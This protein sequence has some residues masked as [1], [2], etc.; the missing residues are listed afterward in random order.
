MQGVFYVR[1]HP[2]HFD[3]VNA[4]FALLCIK[5]LENLLAGCVHVQHGIK[6]SDKNRH[7]SCIL[8]REYTD[9]SIRNTISEVLQSDLL[10]KKFLNF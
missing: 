7:A 4:Y 9:A 8:I 6:Q 1:S 2:D 10:K 3:F 5:R